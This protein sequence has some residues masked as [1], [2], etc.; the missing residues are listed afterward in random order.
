MLSGIIRTIKAAFLC[1]DDRIN[2][3]RISP[4]NRDADLSQ[5]SIR[6]AVALET[7]PSHAIVLGSVKPASWTATGEK[8]RLSSSLPERCE[9]NIGVVRIKNDVGSSGIFIFG[10]N[11]C[12]RLPTV[13]SSKRSE[14]RRVG[15]ERI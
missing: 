10:Q 1:L 15:K 3:V 8:P 2:P 7:F 12:P 11:F 13:G 4:R 14:E 6:K 5:N 9:N